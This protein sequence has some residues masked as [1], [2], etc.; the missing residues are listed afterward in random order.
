MDQQINLLSS[1]TK[2]NGTLNIFRLLIVCTT[3]IQQL[4]TSIY[5]YKCHFYK[6]KSH[7][8]TFDHFASIPVVDILPFWMIIIML[9]H[10][11]IYISMLNV[12][13]TVKHIH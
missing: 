2:T 4:L 10:L 8:P 9:T 7:I 3:G 6:N 12:Y 11:H 1:F 13:D 5:K